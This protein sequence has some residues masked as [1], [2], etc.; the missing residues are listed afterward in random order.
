MKKILK[1][2]LVMALS[3][4]MV[5]TPIAYLG[6][7]PDTVYASS[8]QY[9]SDYNMHVLT[10]MISGVESYH[11]TYSDERNW[12]SF[13]E[14]YNCTSSEVSIT[15]GWAQNFGDEGR[16]LLQMIHDEYPSDFAENDTAGIAGDLNRSWTSYP[17]YQPSRTSAKGK[18]IV[19]IISSEGGKKCQ[20]ELFAQLMN[21]YL[22][23]AVAFGVSKSDPVGLCF[24]CEIE[25][26]GGLN[27]VKR[28]FKK[29]QGTFS[30][31]NIL[32]ILRED[33]WD[34]TSDHQVGDEIF[35]TRHQCIYNW[36]KQYIHTDD[37]SVFYAKGSTGDGVKDIQIKLDILGYECGSADGQY[38]NGTFNAVRAFQSDNASK[39]EVD[40]V[41]GQATIKAINDA[42]ANRASAKGTEFLE[43]FTNALKDVT[44]TA[45]KHDYAYGDSRS[46][47]P[48]SDKV[49]S[50]D[51]MIAKALYNM[52]EDFRDQPVGGM[53]VFTEDSYLTT[54]GF[55]RITDIS[56][57]QDG[58]IILMGAAGVPVHT[59]VAIKYDKTTGICTKFDCGSKPR[60]DTVQP[61]TNVPLLQ[62][63]NPSFMCAYRYKTVADFTEPKA[64][65]E[66]TETNSVA[67]GQKWLNTYYPST[68]RKAVG[69]F[70]D[71][72]GSY[73]TLTKYATLAVWKDLVNRKY[74]YHLTITNHNFGD[75]C[76]QAAAKAT[77]TKG[78]TGTLAFIVQFLLSVK[79][80]YTGNL[81]AEFGDGTFAAV[82]AFQS[83]SG[84]D[85]DG[86]VGANTWNM[87][88]N[89]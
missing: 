40:G 22:S 21:K 74:G 10:N 72:D 24:W 26:L 82:M 45:R 88:F 29:L 51:R 67:Q 27:A 81:D 25:H 42:Y 49:I 44:D 64:T 76:K 30:A 19:A 31:D 39:L 16:K 17:Y 48:T 43:Q 79:G 6:S 55:R 85:S 73:G 68:V 77:I 20:D 4:S 57:V 59:F 71:V 13:A 52:S 9:L 7:S 18:A 32:T 5:M 23:E 2:I 37:V 3:V 28:I 63:A 41:A 36:C 69:A 58:D 80:L 75:T 46:N 84:L 70:L 38:G 60:I 14:A 87:L 66:P 65:P 33:Q 89:G 35:W 47:P 12:S 34:S 78:S 61:F 83:A 53:T 8:S 86:I 11:Q 62:W 54:H 56:K 1:R 15:L 50:C